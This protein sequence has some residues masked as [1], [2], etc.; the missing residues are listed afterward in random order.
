MYSNSNLDMR[1]EGKKWGEMRAK[2]CRSLKEN[3]LKK[4]KQ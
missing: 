2:K 1:N 4:T 3:L